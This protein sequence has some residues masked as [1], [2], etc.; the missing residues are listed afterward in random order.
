MFAVECF[1]NGALPG[2][3]VKILRQHGRPR[4]GLKRQPMRAGCREGGNN[5]QHLA[6]LAEHARII[7]ERFVPVNDFRGPLVNVV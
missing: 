7:V 1:L 5:H 6:K 4:D 3:G 2:G